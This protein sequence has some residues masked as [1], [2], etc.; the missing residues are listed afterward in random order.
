MLTKTKAARVNIKM[1]RGTTFFRQ[2]II[3]G[4]SVPV[5][6]VFHLHILAA[7]TDEDALTEFTSISLISDL[8]E[9]FSMELAAADT[10]LAALPNTVYYHKIEAIIPDTAAVIRVAD[11]TL[12]LLP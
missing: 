5:G 12:T 2:F 6:T 11:G 1:Q 8:G 7:E 10:L 3:K 4:A 9:S